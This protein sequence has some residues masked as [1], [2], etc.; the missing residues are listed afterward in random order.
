MRSAVR[1]SVLAACFGLPAVAQETACRNPNVIPNAGIAACSELIASGVDEASAFA[2]R[3]YHLSH[4]GEYD[5][6]IVDFSEAI[7]LAPQD[8]SAYSYRGYAYDQK[9]DYDRA[10]ADFNEAI[11]LNP[12]DANL[13]NDRGGSYQKKGDAAKAHADFTEAIRLV[14]HFAQAYANRAK[15]YVDVRQFDDAIGDCD[16]AIKLDPKRA[17]AFAIRGSVYEGKGERE[18]ALADFQQALAIDPGLP[19]AIQGRDRLQAALASQ[20]GTAAEAKTML[21]K[22]IAAL[23]S[24][25]DKTLDMINKG[26]GGFL[27]RDLYPFCFNAR[28]GKAIAGASPN[29]KQAL[30]RDVRTLRDAAGKL[31]GEEFYAAAQRP[32]GQITEVSY[33]FPTPSDSTPVAKVSFVTRAAGMGCGVGYYKGTRA[34]SAKE[35]SSSGDGF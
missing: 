19:P 11:R 27:D 13:Y 1:F 14:P 7:R 3:G 4:I 25:R 8:G 29:S 16:E 32:E 9:G 26:E 20:F 17:D 30:G 34:S 22:V 28:D 35:P 31:Y 6:A 33:M 12:T 18:R 21:L 23:K 24:E 2:W 5:R 10:I 15:V